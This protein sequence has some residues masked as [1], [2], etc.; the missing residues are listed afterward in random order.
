[1]ALFREVQELTYGQ[2]HLY[3]DQQLVYVFLASKGNEG[4]GGPSG[5][6]GDKGAQVRKPFHLKK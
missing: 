2:L 4:P 5:Q 3:K 1:M 6:K